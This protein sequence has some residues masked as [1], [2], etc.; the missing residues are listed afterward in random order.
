[1]AERTLTQIKTTAAAQLAA[2]KRADTLDSEEAKAWYKVY[3]LADDSDARETREE[4]TVRAAKKAK[5]RA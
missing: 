5:K 4:P 2:H 1:M 3:K